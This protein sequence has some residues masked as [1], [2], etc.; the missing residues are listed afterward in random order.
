MKATALIVV[1]F[2]LMSV[3]LGAIF[4]WPAG[5]L[6]Y[7]QA[8]TYMGVL[9]IPMFGVLVYFL[10]KDPT[11][12]ERRLRFK[13]KERRQKLILIFAWPSFLGTILLPGF[14]RRFGWSTVPPA[15]IIAADAVVLAAYLFFFLALREN[16]FAGRTIEVERGQKVIAT[17]PYALLRH[18]MYTA[19]LPLYLFTPLALG[20]Y[21]AMLP[22][23]L[24][25]VILIARIFNEE[26]VLRRELAGYPEYML[27]V[28]YRLIPGIW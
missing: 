24:M 15:L 16:R 23:L 5:T 28:K 2:G 12:L 6:Q 27:R 11:V 21:W 25:P 3:V 9:L 17:G 22:A 20:S 19:F 4:F 13:E 26:Q 7:W 10:K 14:D 18:P 1:R 8:W